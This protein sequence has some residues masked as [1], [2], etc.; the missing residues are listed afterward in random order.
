MWRRERRALA[1]E[2]VSECEAFLRGRYAETLVARDADVP[3]WAWT[4][5]LAHGS[6]TDLRVAASNA[7]LGARTTFADARAQLAAHLLDAAGPDCT[8]EELQTAVLAPLELN[9]ARRPAVEHWDRGRWSTAVRTALRSHLR[10][11]GS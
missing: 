1:G 2:L 8:L 9:L 10:T 5:L 3:V 11:R 6:E 4:N 7:P